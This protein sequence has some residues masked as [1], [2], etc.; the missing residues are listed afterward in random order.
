[1][2]ENIANILDVPDESAVV[3]ISRTYSVTGGLRL[4]TPAFVPSHLSSDQIRSI[5][6]YS[7][8]RRAVTIL[9]DAALKKRMNAESR[10]ILES[11]RNGPAILATALHRFPRKMW[12]YKHFPDHPSIHDIVCELA[13][14][15]VIEY[16]HCRSLVASPGSH[17][18][19]IDTLALSGSLG[20]FYENIKDALGIIRAVRRFTYHFLEVL[21]E[22]SWTCAAKLPIHSRLSLDEWLEIRESHFAEHI[23]RMERI[24]SAW[25]EAT[26]PP[27]AVTSAGKTL[28]LESFVLRHRARNT[29]DEPQ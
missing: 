17:A 7:R 16:L 19:G 10:R 15:E 11:F 24:Y 21:P 23:Q 3:R 13:D 9:R 20:Y 1:L 14:T 29:T 6:N 28:P 25:L 22:D 5:H 4:V 18:F 27:K 2:D 12:V 8:T 26:S